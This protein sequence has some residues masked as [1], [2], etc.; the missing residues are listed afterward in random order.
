MKVTDAPGKLLGGTLQAIDHGFVRQENLSVV[1][2]GRH[3]SKSPKSWIECRDLE[4]NR[5]GRHGVM[6]QRVAV[7]AA[8]HTC[9]MPRAI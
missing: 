8:V 7:I 3:G 4:L 5:L 2:I 9:W 6:V 1:R